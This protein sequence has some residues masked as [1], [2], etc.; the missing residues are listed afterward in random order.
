MYGMSRQTGRALS[1]VEHV[2]QSI[3]DI[4]T[5][6]IGSR[7]WRRDYGSRLPDLLDN[8]INAGTLLDIYTASADAIAKWEPR[9]HLKKIQWAELQ[10]DYGFVGLVLFG[11][12]DLSIGNLVE[13]SRVSVTTVAL[14]IAFTPEPDSTTP[15]NPA[16][17]TGL[18][19]RVTYDP[20]AVW[21]GATSSI[22][23]PETPQAPIMVFANGVQVNVEVGTGKTLQVAYDVTGDLL[24]VYYMTEKSAP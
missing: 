23:L 16:T 19:S 14:D 12:I 2:R 8:P 3:V 7:V 1:G 17:A 9:F 24:T 18:V 4:L 6:P 11:D 13:N 10:P 15:T 21:D 22:T 5:T 20:P